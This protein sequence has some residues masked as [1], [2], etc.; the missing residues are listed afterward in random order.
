M[1]KTFVKKLS[2]NK[3]TVS[4]LDAASMSKVKGGETV[5]GDECHDFITDPFHTDNTCATCYTDC[6]QATCDDLITG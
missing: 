4:N 6:A 2:L 3:T 1:K 5:K